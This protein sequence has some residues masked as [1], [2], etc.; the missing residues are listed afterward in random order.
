MGTRPLVGDTGDVPQHVVHKVRG[1]EDDVGDGIEDDGDGG[2][3]LDTALRDGVLGG[4]VDL[5]A[6]DN[7]TDGDGDDGE[8]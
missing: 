3:A 8:C 4:E 7:A 6:G 2:A 5:V 1:V